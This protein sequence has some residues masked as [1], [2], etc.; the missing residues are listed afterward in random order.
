LDRAAGRS[1]Q[2]WIRSGEQA[3]SRSYVSPDLRNSVSAYFMGLNA[4]VA[5]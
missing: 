5:E 3:V 2:G 1:E 4:R